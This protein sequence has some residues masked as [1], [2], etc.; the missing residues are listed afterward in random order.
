MSVL[1]RSVLN[2]RC[3]V[4]ASCL[5][6]ILVAGSAP[7][8][9]AEVTQDPPEKVMTMMVEAIKA[10]SYADFLIEADAKV[11]SAITPQMFEGVSNQVAPLLEAGYK[12]AFLAKLKKQVATMYL[13]KLECSNGKEDL[14][15]TMA[16]KN[17]KVAGFTVQ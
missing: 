9:R 17:K 11:Q 12:T 2:R 4:V 8:A 1:N 14:L 3:T 15:I 13:W 6:G 7:A 10:K 5:V 16:V